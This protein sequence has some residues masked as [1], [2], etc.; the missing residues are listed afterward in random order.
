MPSLPAQ[1]VDQM[2][3]ENRALYHPNF[4]ENI[5]HYFRATDVP[6]A[7]V[8]AKAGVGFNANYLGQHGGP[9]AREVLVP[10]L[11]HGIQLTNTQFVPALWELLDFL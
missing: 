11:L 2:S 9:A 3:V 10:L 1:C 7:I 6:D 8:V 5:A 4:L